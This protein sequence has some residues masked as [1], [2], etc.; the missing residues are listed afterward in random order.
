MTVLTGVA[1]PGSSGFTISALTVIMPVKNQTALALRAVRSLRETL[2]EAELVIVDNNSDDDSLIEAT[3]GLVDHIITSGGTVGD[4]RLAGVAIA[5]RTVLLFLDADQQVSRT[6]IEDALRILANCDAVVLPERPLRGGFLPDLLGVERAW[7]EWIGLGIPRLFR[8]DAYDCSAGHARGL[9][10]SED[11]AARIGIKSIGISSEPIF[12]DEVRK[13]RILLAKYHGYGT[14]ISHLYAK[15]FAARRP[16]RY[17]AGRPYLRRHDVVLLPGVLV[18][19]TLK[20]AA[21]WC[22]SQHG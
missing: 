9:A 18:V 11:W 20:L 8:R 13:L 5:S 3:K 15:T 1:V 19:K 2:P 21:L 10:F 6:A 17:T 22:G 12:H 16:C 7:T 14:S 4:A